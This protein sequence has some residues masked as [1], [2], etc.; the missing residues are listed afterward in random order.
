MSL[1]R[2][3]DGRLGTWKEGRGFKERSWRPGA[4]SLVGLGLGHHPH[5]YCHQ[6][7]FIKWLVLRGQ[8]EGTR[9]SFGTC[10]SRAQGRTVS[11]HVEFHKSPVNVVLWSLVFNNKM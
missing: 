10:L 11:F 7:A 4:P 6:E 9:H 8:T 1:L 2:Q 3:G 5:C